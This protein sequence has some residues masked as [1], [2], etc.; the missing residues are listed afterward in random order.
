MVPLRISGNPETEFS[1]FDLK[2]ANRIIQEIAAEILTYLQFARQIAEGRV[3]EFFFNMPMSQISLSCAQTAHPRSFPLIL[4]NAQSHQ[5]G[6][7]EYIGQPTCWCSVPV[8]YYRE[9]LI[10]LQFTLINP[11]CSFVGRL[12]F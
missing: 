10:A 4:T 8:R 12:S 11:C 5:T 6:L 9:F 3:S 2:I 1:F 7:S